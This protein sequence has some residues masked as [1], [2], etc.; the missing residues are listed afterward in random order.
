MR[1]PPPQHSLSTI[2]RDIHTAMTELATLR[3]D[4]SSLIHE[5]LHNIEANSANIRSW[6]TQRERLEQEID[7]LQQ[8]P[9]SI[10]VRKLEEDNA[11][12]DNQIEV[13]E[14]QLA[15][16]QSRRRA[17]RLELEAGK[18]RFNATLSSYHAA[19][20][21]VDRDVATF[22]AGFGKTQDI[23]GSQTTTARWMTQSGGPQSQMTLDD[24]AEKN[25]TQADSLKE[26]NTAAKAEQAALTAGIDVWTEVLDGIRTFEKTLASHLRRRRE[27]RLA[28]SRQSASNG[29]TDMEVLELMDQTMAELEVRLAYVEEQGWNLLVCAIGAEVQA[30][31]LGREMLAE[32]LGVND[33]PARVAYTDDSAG[34]DGGDFQGSDLHRRRTS[35]DVRASILHD[36]TTPER[37]TPPQSPVITFTRTLPQHYA[38]GSGDDEPDDDML[39]TMHS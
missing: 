10:Q 22:L 28:M 17:G 21:Q 19:L 32:M 38:E 24:A 23:R 13:L 33:G 11:A 31:G 4:E 5:E 16:L 9:E 3:N 37:S 20:S 34:H 25:S 15:E 30:F 29:M 26:A 2:R 12:L 35:R 39:G 7:H 1:Q 8:T 6:Q 14:I 27:T 36:T 18:N